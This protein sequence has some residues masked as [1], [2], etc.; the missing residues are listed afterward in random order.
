MSCWKLYEEQNIYILIL[1][2]APLNYIREKKN[3]F[4]MEMVVM[5]YLFQVIQVSVTNNGTN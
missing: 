5:N 2:D 3:D 4:I 1:M